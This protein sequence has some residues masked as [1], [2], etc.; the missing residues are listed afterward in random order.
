[1]LCYMRWDLTGADEIVLQA[2]HRYALV[3]GIVAEASD[4]GFTLANLNNAGDPAAPSFADSY[5]G[6]FAVR[7]EGEGTLPPAMVPGPTAVPALEGQSRFPAGSARFALTPTTDG[8]PD[9][10]TYRDLE[11]YIE[12]SA[13]TRITGK[14]SSVTGTGPQTRLHRYNAQGRFMKRPE[15]SQPSR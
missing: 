10:D 13:A 6:G 9:V 12:G 14:A 8:Y 4:C 11:F 2:G 3:F 5:S 15:S 1:M 7:R